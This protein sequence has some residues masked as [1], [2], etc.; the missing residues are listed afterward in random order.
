M[1][2]YI[3]NKIPFIVREDLGYFDSEMEAVFIE[4]KKNI[5]NI[6]NN[7]SVHLILQLLC[8]TI[9][10]IA[11]SHS[12][13]KQK[14]LCSNRKAWLTTALEQSISRVKIIIHDSIQRS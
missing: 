5:A 8:S 7:I 13:K 4:I 12:S 11:A 9:R 6:K 10:I 2:V 3:H 14:K 1:S